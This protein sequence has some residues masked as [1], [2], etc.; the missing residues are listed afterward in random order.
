MKQYAN[1]V[2]AENMQIQINSDGHI[3]DILDVTVDYSKYD[4]VVPI[5]EK[6]VTTR[7]GS[8]R[9]YHTTEG[10]HLLV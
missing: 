8:R 7:S 1:N 3:F 5:S 4:T 6:Y 2:I 10:W 9:I